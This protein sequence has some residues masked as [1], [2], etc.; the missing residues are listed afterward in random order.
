[1]TQP[2]GK[3]V[4]RSF[5]SRKKDAALDRPL[6]ERR[7]DQRQAEGRTNRRRPGPMS[8]AGVA[9]RTTH[10]WATYAFDWQADRHV[11]IWKSVAYT[12]MLFAFMLPHRQ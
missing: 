8:S 7:G 11:M 4:Y 12:L 6:A 5:R 10:I 2:W 1:V 9:T 3:A